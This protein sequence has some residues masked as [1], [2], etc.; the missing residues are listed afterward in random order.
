MARRRNEAKILDPWK[1]GLGL[2][3]GAPEG[4]APAISTA[5]MRRM[6][7]LF[8]RLRQFP[9]KIV[10]DLS[11]HQRAPGFFTIVAGTCMLGTQN[12]VIANAYA[13]A[14]V[15]W[16][17]GLGLWFLVMYAFFT[18]VTIRE[19]KPP[20]A[21]G[22]S[23]A[24][25]MAAVATQSLVALRAALAA[26]DSSPPGIQFLCL[27]LYMIG[28]ML[29]LAMIPLILYRLTFVR[30]AA[31]DFSPPYWID[32]GAAG[33]TALAGSILVLQADKWALL[34][35][36][37]PFLKDLTGLLLGRRG[38]VDTVPHRTHGL[39]VSGAKG[40]CSLRATSLGHGL[41]A[42]HVRDGNLRAFA[43]AGIPFPRSHIPHIR[44]RRADDWVVLAFAGLLTQLARSSK[45]AH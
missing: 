34:Q 35:D 2:R 1:F 36:Y 42:G 29:Y 11:E 31:Q 14:T 33:I 43:R 27:A 37:L 40:S 23:G 24:W 38:V 41:S 25:L 32:M 5:V 17:A 22:I 28:C 39:A 30:F 15:L 19:R 12:V 7:R 3:E 44:V 20:L 21:S 8:T 18:A 10:E 16:F 4:I 45:G 13:V 6:V 26:G 9:A